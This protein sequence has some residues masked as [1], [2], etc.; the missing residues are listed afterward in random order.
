MRRGLEKVVNDSYEEKVSNS[1][2]VSNSIL[3]LNNDRGRPINVIKICLLYGQTI[4]SCLFMNGEM[5]IVRHSLMH[6][7]YIPKT[8]I[9]RV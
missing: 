2:R 4:Y 6:G 7:V 1:F 5:T 9:V 3:P 8:E